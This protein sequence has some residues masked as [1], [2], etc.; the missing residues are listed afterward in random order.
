M[1][2]M[3]TYFISLKTNLYYVFVL[4]SI[5]IC[6][7]LEILY[8]GFNIFQWFLMLFLFL[9]VYNDL[10]FNDFIL[11]NMEVGVS[12]Y[13]NRNFKIWVIFVKDI[14]NIY[15]QKEIIFDHYQ[16]IW[17]SVQNILVVIKWIHSLMTNK[18][19]KKNILTIF[20]CL[21]LITNI[22]QK[23]ISFLK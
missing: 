2:L 11:L 23:L 1:K 17:V 13:N 10:L 21:S 15:Y 19:K 12:H 22:S 16:N 9:F 3:L 18:Q 6:L 8:Q 4:R 20:N 14:I 7:C 5:I